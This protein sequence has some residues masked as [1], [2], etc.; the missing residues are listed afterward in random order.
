MPKKH[1]NP[2]QRKK[3]QSSLNGALKYFLGGCVAEL[4]LL[5]VR[6]YYVNGTVDQVP[7]WDDYL[8]YLLYF[9]VAL[10]VAGAAL[11]YVWRKGETW[12]KNTAWAVLAAGLFLAVGNAILRFVYPTG[13]MIMS[14]LVPAVMFLGILWCLYPRECF[15]SLG[16]LAA[17]IMAAWVCRKGAGTVYWGTPVLIGACVFLVLLAC[18]ALLGRKAQQGG[19]MLSSWRAMPVGGNYTVIYA[20]CAVSAAAT[21]IS[22]ISSAAGYYAIWA[23]ALAVFALAVYYT[24]KEL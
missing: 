7:V 3:N 2:E 12:K 15:Y 24:V 8:R 5:V 18:V 13:S 19:G 23:V 14:V 20:S 17:G 10:A 11:M 21:V 16:V 1:E 4:Y 22:L 9:G 6:K